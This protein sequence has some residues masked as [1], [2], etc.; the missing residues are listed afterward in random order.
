MVSKIIFLI[1]ITIAWS[2]DLIEVNID[3]TKINEGDTFNLIVTSKN[4]SQ[5]FDITLPKMDRIKIVSGPNKSSSTSIQIVNGEMTKMST[6]TYTWV[7]L[8]LK[9]GKS[10]I[11]SLKFD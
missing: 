2:Q 7:L 10:I 8:P 3:K 6:K 11:P 5:D 1:A 9:T 4:Q